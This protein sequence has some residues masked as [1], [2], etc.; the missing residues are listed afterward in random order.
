MSQITARKVAL[1]RLVTPWVVRR[2]F[3][4]MLPALI[5]ICIRDEAGEYFVVDGRPTAIPYLI[6]TSAVA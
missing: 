5:Y 3:F 6:L 1:H 4:E 2:R